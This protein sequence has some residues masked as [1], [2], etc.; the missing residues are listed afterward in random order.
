MTIDV[1]RALVEQQRNLALDEPNGRI[2]S[3]SPSVVPAPMQTPAYARAVATASGL[4][5]AE[6]VEEIVEIRRR[7]QRALR[8][9]EYP[10]TY[11]VTESAL[12]RTIG[13]VE[14]MAEQRVLLLAL[15]ELAHV[16][17]RVLPEQDRHPVIWSCGFTITENATSIEGIPF[18]IALPIKET[19]HY[20]AHFQDLFH[21]ARPYEL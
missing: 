15:A 14:V 16:T 1:S 3:F 10:R 21:A 2:R 18:S 8:D 13:G 9:A 17:L 11:V 7:R 5:R 20:L 12:R 4:V 6:H 19:R